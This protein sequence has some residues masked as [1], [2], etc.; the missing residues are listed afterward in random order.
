VITGPS[1]QTT[2]IAIVDKSADAIYIATLHQFG[3]PRSKCSRPPRSLTIAR[4]YKGNE[5]AGKPT[6]PWEMEVT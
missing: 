5:P 2:E 1:F 3:I 6:R 4:K